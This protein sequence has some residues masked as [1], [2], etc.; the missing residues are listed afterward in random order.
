MVILIPRMVVYGLHGPDATIRYVGRTKKTANER[1]REHIASC[2][3]GW[4][5]P[6]EEWITALGADSISAVVLAECDSPEEL[7]ELEVRFI[8]IYKRTLLNVRDNPAA[9]LRAKQ[10]YGKVREFVP[11]LFEDTTRR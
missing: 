9:V 8:H 6:L 3:R 4:Q 7:A 5:T 2:K 10:R 11:A 1:L